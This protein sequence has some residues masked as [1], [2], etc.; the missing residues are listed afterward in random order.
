MVS[1]EKTDS[2]TSFE[3]YGFTDNIEKIIIVFS[4]V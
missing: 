2:G 4:D 1:V 3:I